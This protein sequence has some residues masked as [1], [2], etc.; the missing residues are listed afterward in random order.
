M[1]FFPPGILFS[2]EIIITTDP[3]GA[4]VILNRKYIGKTPLKFQEGFLPF[5]EYSIKITKEGYCALERT[6]TANH[7]NI[8]DN[9]FLFNFVGTGSFIASLLTI[10][11]PLISS[12]L[13]I[14]SITNEIIGA[15][16]SDRYHFILIKNDGSSEITYQEP[17]TAS[18]PIKYFSGKEHFPINFGVATKIDTDG[19]KKK[20]ITSIRR[21]SLEY[22][23]NIPTG[24]GS[25]TEN[26]KIEY[27]IF[28]TMG[29]HLTST[30]HQSQFTGVGV[31]FHYIL[32]L[33][34]IGPHSA[35][36][37]KSDLSFFRAMKK[38]YLY[39]L[40]DIQGDFKITEITYLF[41]GTGIFYDG[42]LSEVENYL[43][44]GFG[45]LF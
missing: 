21:F 14:F 15:S 20:I 29:F 26:I 33:W 31:G 39:S 19:K 28:K 37:L 44:A 16:L 13:I 2:H 6:I 3:P 32:P 12:S 41:G 11:H 34:D 42:D 43:Q 4:D 24:K 36:Q 25:G 8:S 10:S 1:L 18:F 17:V 5:K 30:L 40:I 22:T 9:K 23:I 35:I 7:L 45:V 38:H 27:L